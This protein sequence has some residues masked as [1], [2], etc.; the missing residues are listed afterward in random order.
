MNQNLIAGK[1][2]IKSEGEIKIFSNKQ[3]LKE[4]VIYRLDLQEILK[5]VLQYETT[6]DSNLEH[7]TWAITKASIIVTMVCN[8]IFTYQHDLRD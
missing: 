5:G 1:T 8:C 4:F 6:L 7:N 3:K 2:S